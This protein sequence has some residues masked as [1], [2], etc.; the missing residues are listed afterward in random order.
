MH[1]QLLFVFRLLKKDFAAEIFANLDAEKQESIVTSITDTEITKLFD[2]LYIDDAVDLLEELPAGVVN[3]IIKLSTPET[4]DEINK[5]LKYPEDS[6]GSVMTSEFISLNAGITVLEASEKIRATGYA[7]ETIYVIY[8]TDNSNKT[9][10]SA[11]AIN[12]ANIAGSI[13]G[14]T[15]AMFVEDTTE[16]A[17]NVTFSTAG[18]GSS[19]NYYVSGVKA[20]EW[21]VSVGTT[22][23]NVTVGEGEGILHF[24]AP[25]G[26][27]SISYV[28]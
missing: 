27:V 9:L 1:S 24:T 10:Y 17:G 3:K 11:T 4:R 8:V 15:V 16:Y 6:A 2:E 5:F 18:A 21:R 13:I 26:A 14:N 22:T 20:G 7:K 23:L 25:S 19:L 28:G 12:G